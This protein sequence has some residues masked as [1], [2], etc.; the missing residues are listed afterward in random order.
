MAT[1]SALLHAYV[2]TKYPELLFFIFDK[3]KQ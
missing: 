1:E 3:H 2:S